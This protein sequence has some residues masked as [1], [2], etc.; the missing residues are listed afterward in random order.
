MSN[1][2][3]FQKDKRAIVEYPHCGQW[4]VVYTQC[5]SCGAPVE[6]IPPDENESPLIACNHCGQFGADKKECVHCGAPMPEKLVRINDFYDTP[7]WIDG[8]ASTNSPY[9][10]AWMSAGEHYKWKD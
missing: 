3:G 8:N 7:Y 5:G 6:R 4:A 1:W 9:F 10:S 2:L